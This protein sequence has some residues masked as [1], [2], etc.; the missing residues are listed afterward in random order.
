MRVQFVLITN[1]VIDSPKVNNFNETSQNYYK[2]I[3]L[4]RKK[5]VNIN[6][7]SI[8]YT[9][10]CIYCTIGAKKY[11]RMIDYFYRL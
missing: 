10:R 3:K 6:S 4:N 1:L 11:K 2:L 7:N 9:N 8:I 5:S